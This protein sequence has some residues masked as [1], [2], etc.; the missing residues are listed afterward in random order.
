MSSTQKPLT[1]VGIRNLK[2]GES[3]SDPAPRGAGVLQVRKLSNGSTAFYFRYTDSK[4]AR[5]RLSLGLDVTLQDARKRAASLSR[6]YQDGD[7]DLRAV[8]DAEVLEARRVKEAEAVRQESLRAK[9]A[10]T[11]GAL[12]G[13][14]C[15]FLEIRKKVSAPKVRKAL[16]KHVRDSSP[17]LWNKPAGDLDV[18]DLASLVRP[19]VDS[20]HL[21]EAAKIR[22]YLQAAYAA[23]VSARQGVNGS[24]ALRA[25]RISR[26]PAKDL[27]TVDAAE[28]K[29]QRVLAESELRAYWQAISAVQG[30]GG[31]LLRFHLLTGCQRVEQLAR[32][33]TTDVDSDRPSFRIYDPK[34]RRKTPRTHEVPLLPVALTAIDDMDLRLG[35]FVA[36]ID[37]GTSGAEYSSYRHRLQDVVRGLLSD[38]KLPGGSFSVGDLRRTVETRLAAAGVSLEVRAQLQSHGLGGVQARHYD[39]YDYFS[40]KLDALKRLATIIGI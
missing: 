40:E 5:D 16:A 7:T 13:A 24:P 10:A 29:R 3:A 6:R 34:G 38:G 28:S 19:L 36:S 18:D 26:N 35:P 31:A 9:A 33:K 39:K 12:V 20:G 32:L 21:R 14:Y 17:A 25:L 27:S 15:D 2:A 4:G 8:L 11:L 30:P 37:H 1:A 22:S 23:A